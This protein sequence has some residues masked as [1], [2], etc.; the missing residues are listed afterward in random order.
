MAVD[1]GLDYNYSTAD[2]PFYAGAPE[3]WTP[4]PENKMPK[5]NPWNLLDIGNRALASGAVTPAEAAKNISPVL[6]VLGI[7][8]GPSLLTKRRRPINAPFQGQLVGENPF[9]APPPT[10]V[11]NVPA[12]NAVYQVPGADKGSGRTNKAE[13]RQTQESDN[14][15]SRTNKVSGRDLLLFGPEEMKT[16]Y[17]NINQIP[18]IRDQRAGITKMEELL[19][20]S[21]DGPSDFYSAPIG[22]LLETSYGY[23]GA[24]ERYAAS[25]QAPTPQNRQKEILGYAD[26][27]QGDRNALSQ[28]IID[29]IGKQKAGYQDYLQAE[30]T[31]NGQKDVN[32]NINTGTATDPSLKPKGNGTMPIKARALKDVRD[33]FN[34]DIKIPS[35]ALAFSKTVEDLIGNVG[36]GSKLAKKTVETLL[37]RARGEVGNL[38][39][40]EQAGTATAQDLG[41][42]FNQFFKTL[43]SGELTTENKK[44]IMGLVQIYRKAAKDTIEAYRQKHASSGEAVY[45]ELGLT[46]ETFLP[47]LLSVD[48]PSGG[49]AAGG[50]SAKMVTVISPTGQ[51]GKIPEANLSKAL[52][53]GYKKASD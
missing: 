6:Q 31:K 52:S 49:G 41:E 45:G 42:R 47:A 33:K 3:G 27:I 30:A 28:R 48:V 20:M 14:T 39:Y 16:A 5:K 7:E 1:F 44:Q 40:Y 2:R 4:Y 22:N 10:P 34:A 8:T 24:G 38:S 18:D 21:G 26:K 51:R 17:E 43:E 11:E 23:K 35:T 19:H 32:V 46:R 25:A 37:A 29:L 36:P 53:K 50:G 9:I 12:Q 13:T 15:V